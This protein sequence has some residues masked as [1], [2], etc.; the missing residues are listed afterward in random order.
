MKASI[1]VTD[2]EGKRLSATGSIEMPYVNADIQEEYAKPNVSSP[3]SSN[4]KK[5]FSRSR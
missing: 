4:N 5:P 2:R 1:W 3:K